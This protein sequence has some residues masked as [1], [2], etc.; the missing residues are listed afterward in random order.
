MRS[1]ITPEK[2]ALARQFRKEPT[3]SEDTV[4]QIL[5]NRQILNLKWRR[6][7]VIEG[8]IADFYCA[9]LKLALEIDGEIHNNE[10]SQNYDTVRDEVFADVGINT[11]R[12]KSKEC[13]E[14]TLTAILTKYIAAE[15][16]SLSELPP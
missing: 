3:Q 15:A 5:R 8:F 9:E 1:R 14:D 10:E 11:I 7:H 2:I 13:D 6:Q 12:V 16:P 4:W